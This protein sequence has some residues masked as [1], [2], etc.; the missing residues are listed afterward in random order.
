[1]NIKN[2]QKKIGVSVL[3]FLFLDLLSYIAFF[4]LDLLKISFLI[5]VLAGAALTIY[6]LEYGILI[7]LA[8]LL[9]GSKG[10][11]FYCL[12]AT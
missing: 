12:N 1:M 9:I 2:I 6:K 3:V 4:N 5:I 11:L 10:Y 8:E 7:L